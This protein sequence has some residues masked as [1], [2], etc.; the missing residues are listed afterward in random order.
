M[1]FWAYMLQCRGGYFY[2]GHTD[3]LERR[4]GDHKSGLIPGFTADHQPAELV[5][6]QAFVTRDEAKKAEKQ[7]KGWSR[8]K[9]LALIRGDWERISNLAKGKSSPSTSSGKSEIGEGGAFSNPVYP[10]LVEGL[11]FSLLPHPEALPLNVGSLSARLR[12]QEASL[13][14]SYE[15]APAATLNLP[16]QSRP[17][18]ADELWRTTCF[19]LFL[20]YSG[21]MAY[22]EFNFSPSCQWAAYT[23]TDYREGM[24][25]LAVRLTPTIATL[26]TDEFFVL[27]VA[28]DTE[29]LRNV[30]A[31]AL[32]AVIEETDGTK[33]Y[34]ALAHPPRSHNGGKPDFHHPTCFAAK[35]PPPSVP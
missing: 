8:A 25:N 1:S 13:W 3:D 7:I 30:S 26:R 2:V 18:R 31:I 6:S 17:T 23:F 21:G 32:S 12:R 15:L 24:R 22:S 20:K 35:L 11:S 4:I 34:W 33:S 28:I 14:L 19:E 9:K 27:S 29:L 16:E 5:W 10:E